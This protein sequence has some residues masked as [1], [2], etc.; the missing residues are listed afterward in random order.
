[1]IALIFIEFAFIAGMLLLLGHIIRSEFCE[2]T[3]YF[4]E[5]LEELKQHLDER[6]GK[7]K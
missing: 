1:M 2:T 5:R 4:D 6:L 7:S 3:R